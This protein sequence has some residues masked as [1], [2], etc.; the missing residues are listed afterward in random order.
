MLVAG[1]IIL[2]LALVTAGALIVYF[3]AGAETRARS[4]DGL[5]RGIVLIASGADS[6]CVALLH[7]DRR[8]LILLLGVLLAI[9]GFVTPTLIRL[10]K[11]ARRL[12]DG[13]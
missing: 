3:A 9:Y 10:L 4:S 11:A 12:G 13:R 6:A 5:A 8:L 1:F 7:H 2:A